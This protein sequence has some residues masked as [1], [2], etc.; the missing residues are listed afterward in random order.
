[1]IGPAL[2]WAWDAAPPD[3]ARWLLLDS[4]GCALAGLGHPRPRGFADA[5]ARSMAG[6]IVLPGCAG[7]APA[8]AAAVLAS[9]M[10]WDEANEG[11]AR[12]HGR[13]G[14]ATAPLALAAIAGGAEVDEAV[15]A[16]AAGYEVAGRAGEIFRIKPGMH[17]DGSWHSLGAAVTA[18][19]LA[20]GDV[21]AAGRAMRLAACQIPFSLYAPIA[22]GMDGRNSF[23]AHAVLLGQM[24]AA[25]AMAGMDA[26]EEGFAIACRLALGIETPAAMTP[27]GVWLLAE[28]YTKRFAGVRHAH[29]GAAAALALRD[30]VEAPIAGIALHTYPEALQ[31][32][33][34]R[35]PKTAIAAQFSLSWAVAA[36]LHQGDLGPG[37]YTDAALADPVLQGLEAL[38]GLHEDPAPGR[39]ARLV[40]TLA[41]GRVLEHSARD[42]PMTDDD[43]LDKFLG[44]ARPSLGRD[45]AEATADTLLR[46]NGVARG[47]LRATA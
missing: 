15:A 42:V 30:E 13:P 28:A 40:V 32:A 5:L 41:D 23:A 36:A 14:L 25:A 7:L 27:P 34:A 10:C 12:A 45:G 17:V 47:F 44:F 22:A 26:P 38:V 9:A 3:R 21:A 19:R 18:T 24:C 16:F 20:G 33:G 43:V 37:A 8:G 39:F 2:A 6:G 35:A 31:Y 29:Y 11:L 1:M 46:G 4:L